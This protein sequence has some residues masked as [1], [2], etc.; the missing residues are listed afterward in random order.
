[1]P[2]AASPGR[3][4]A[5]EPAGGIFTPPGATVAEARSPLGRNFPQA[6]SPSAPTVDCFASSHHAGQTFEGFMQVRDF[7]DSS[8][9]Q[10]HAAL[11]V[12]FRRAP[13]AR[14]R[15]PVGDRFASGGRIAQGSFG[16]LRGKGRPVPAWC[17]GWQKLRAARAELPGRGSVSTLFSAHCHS[18]P[19]MS[20]VWCTDPSC[21]P[22]AQCP[23]LWCQP[24]VWMQPAS[25]VDAFRSA[26]GIPKHLATCR[27]QGQDR[28]LAF[29]ACGVQ[30]I[31]ARP[32]ACTCSLATLAGAVRLQLHR[33]GVCG[34]GSCS[35]PLAN[36]PRPLEVSLAHQLFYEAVLSM[37]QWPQAPAHAQRNVEA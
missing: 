37:V 27:R 26:V 22:G 10:S 33:H 35:I 30:V 21:H 4:E 15:P 31:H 14:E 23:C 29:G 28:I 24:P 7:R 13:A 8:R 18:I 34:H 25:K 6:A 5:V 32:R 1:M 17:V 36:H 3:A 2:R 9:L 16:A 19:S 20:P 12:A 11:P